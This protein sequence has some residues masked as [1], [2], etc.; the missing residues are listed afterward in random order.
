MADIKPNHTLYIN[1][2]NEKVKKDGEW[3]FAFAARNI[4]LI[5]YLRTPLQS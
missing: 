2:L 1:N 3:F 4:D 5:L